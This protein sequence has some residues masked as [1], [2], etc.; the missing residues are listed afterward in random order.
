MSLK[1]ISAKEAKELVDTEGYTLVDVRSIPE[2]TE[3]HPEGAYNI[4]FLHKAPHGMVPNQDFAKVVE[5]TF[6]EKSTKLV[7]SCQMGGRSVRAA[8]ELIG[9]GYTEVVDLR[10]GFGGE[11]DPDGK[12]LVEGW[13][14]EGL[15]VQS[16]E[17]EGRAY[18]ALH[19][20]ATTTEDDC[21][22]DAPAAPPEPEMNRFAHATRVVLCVKFG[23]ELPALKRTPMGGP[24]GKRLKRQV[25][26]KAWNLWVE[27]SKMIINEYRLNP[28]EPKSQEILMKQCDEF[29]FGD[30]AKLPEDFVPQAAGK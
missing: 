25:S 29:F 21:G 4:P 26:A 18:R 8:Q 24:M 15:P 16:G 12:V 22:P 13:K 23:K 9:L 2:F 1:R 3:A 17:P 5:R 19:H 14:G 6:P 28:A 11:T 7:T 27:H 10:G 30:G 20:T